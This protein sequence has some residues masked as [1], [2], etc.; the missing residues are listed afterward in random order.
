MNYDF[1]PT[2]GPAALPEAFVDAEHWNTLKV[3]DAIA[4]MARRK[5]LRVPDARSTRMYWDWLSHLS[6]IGM[7]S[8][9]TI[10]NTNDPFPTQQQWAD[11]LTLYI[12]KN[13][14]DDTDAYNEAEAYA[15]NATAFQFAKFDPAFFAAKT[16][17]T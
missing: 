11:A 15:E 7:A 16:L 10:M 14:D 13:S 8:L 4:A 6:K 1:I 12:R 3:Y 5:K 2:A 17:T 9:A